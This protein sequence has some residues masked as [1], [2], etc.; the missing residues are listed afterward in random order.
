MI[1]DHKML[2]TA[3]YGQLRLSVRGGGGGAPLQPIGTVVWPAD[4]VA[5]RDETE[6]SGASTAGWNCNRP[7]R[8]LLELGA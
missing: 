2:S 4:A 6:G 7:F 1:I 3:G 5:G 8:I